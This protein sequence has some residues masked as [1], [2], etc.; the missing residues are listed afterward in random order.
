M[1]LMNQTFWELPLFHPFYFFEA[2]PPIPVPS[3]SPPIPPAIYLHGSWNKV[4]WRSSTSVH[5]KEHSVLCTTVRAAVK[6]DQQ[7]DLSC[8]AT[9][10]T[11]ATS[12]PPRDHSVR[13]QSA[14][15][16][17]HMHVERGSSAVHSS[18]FQ[19]RMWIVTLFFPSLRNGGRILYF[20]T[21]TPSQSLI[22][23]KAFPRKRACPS[24]FPVPADMTW[25]G[26]WEN[27]SV[28][29]SSRL[30][31]ILAAPCCW[32]LRAQ[33]T[34]MSSYPYPAPLLLGCQPTHDGRHDLLTSWP[35]VGQGI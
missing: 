18:I 33:R 22:I 24:H 4:G 32:L 30:G 11:L 17:R 23:A 34:L 8:C 35:I 7:H 21:H 13:L 26:T 29:H 20:T 10:G 2:A 1:L 27:T 3:L 14:D 25:P 5:G 6:Q 16:L 12:E 28:C 31:L 19:P 15:T 9:R